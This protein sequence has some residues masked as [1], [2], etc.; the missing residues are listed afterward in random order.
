M[1]D[2]NVSNTSDITREGGL[3][4]VDRSTLDDE[5]DAVLSLAMNPSGEV[6]AA[7]Q[8]IANNAS[9]LGPF[10][11]WATAL[12]F[13][14]VLSKRHHEIL[15]LR[16]SYNC[17][18]AFEWKEHVGWAKDAGLTDAEID[19][20]A[21]GC[22]GWPTTE[23]LLIRFADELHVRRSATDATLAALTEVLDEASVVEAVFVVG[24]YS[25]LS[26]LC[27]VARLDEN[28]A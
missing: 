20:V 4:R 26:S 3:A 23:A 1:R 21:A 2:S 28:D 15:A 6:V 16:T 9:L 8:V 5:T 10:L 7:V 25:M 14:G 18:S 24:Q 22:E 13:E 19:A 12:H 27:A 17:D 11:T